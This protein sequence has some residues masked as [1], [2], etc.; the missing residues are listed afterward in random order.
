MSATTYLGRK[1]ALGYLN[2]ILKKYKA[3]LCWDGSFTLEDFFVLDQKGGFEFVIMKEA[4]EGYCKEKAIAD[5]NRFCVILFRHFK[6]DEADEKYPAYFDQFQVDYLVHMP[7]REDTEAYARWQ[8]YMAHHFAFKAPQDRS[9]LVTETYE[10]CDSMRNGPDYDLLNDEDDLEPWSND[11]TSSGSISL[12]DT[13]EYGSVDP[14]TNRYGVLSYWKVLIF[15][16]HFS[17]HMLRA[18]RVFIYFAFYS[19]FC[20]CRCLYV[21]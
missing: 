2:F 8:K 9:T 3:G 17:R 6:D 18:K 13:Y 10:V 11:V 7:N 5:F 1:A 14:N 21:L 4:S 19:L 12:I 20:K 15:G 16:R